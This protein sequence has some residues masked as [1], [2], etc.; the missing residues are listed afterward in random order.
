MGYGEKECGMMSTAQHTNSDTYA[1]RG[2]AQVEF[3]LQDNCGGAMVDISS[4]NSSYE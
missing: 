4:I 2:G 1:A 3:K